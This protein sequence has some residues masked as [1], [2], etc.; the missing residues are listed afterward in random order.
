E[1]PTSHPTGRPGSSH[2]RPN[3]GSEWSGEEAKSCRASWLRLPLFKEGCDRHDGQLALAETRP[4]SLL[5]ELSQI[6]VMD[7]H[8]LAVY[9]DVLAAILLIEL[10][11]VLDRPAQVFVSL[12]K[13]GDLDRVVLPGVGRVRHGI[14]LPTAGCLKPS[15][16]VSTL[17]K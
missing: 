11:I 1:W 14:A 5:E 3:A 16:M 4:G 7:H 13:P 6:G 2:H 9:R 17:V 10:R 15:S 8:L 12:A